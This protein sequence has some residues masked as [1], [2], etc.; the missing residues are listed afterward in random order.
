M[1][2]ILLFLS[3]CLCL[4]SLP[5]FAQSVEDAYSS[6][7]PG[8]AYEPGDSDHK[9]KQADDESDAGVYDSSNNTS[10]DHNASSGHDGH[11]GGY[12]GGY[13]E[14]GGGGRR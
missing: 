11:S 5:A 13:G 6:A 1:K 3:L 7:A 4:A 10:P 12:G 14:H 9:K 2:K 8:Q